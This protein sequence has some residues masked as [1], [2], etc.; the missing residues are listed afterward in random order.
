MTEEEYDQKKK[1][2]KYLRERVRRTKIANNKH[3][4]VQAQRRLQAAIDATTDKVGIPHGEIIAIDDEPILILLPTAS[5]RQ[6]LPKEVIKKIH[7]TKDEEAAKNQKEIKVFTEEITWNPTEVWKEGDSYD[8]ICPTGGPG[9]LICCHDCAKK[10]CSF[11]DETMK[12]LEVQRTHK[13]GNEVKEIV[14]LLEKSKN[15]LEQIGCAAR[16]KPP[17][18]FRRANLQ[19]KPKATATTPRNRSSGAAKQ[20][21]QDED[22]EWNLTSAFDIVQPFGTNQ[23]GTM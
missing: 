17:P 20:Q 2:I 11:L 7:E 6:P 3:A 4:V 12:D 19:D 13:L 5:R 10:Y 15:E 9:G 1:E 16:R 8:K 21:S 14:S 18:A 23:A 22:Q